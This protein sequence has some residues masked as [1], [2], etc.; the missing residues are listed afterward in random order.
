MFVSFVAFQFVI[1]CPNSTY[2]GPFNSC[3]NMW[4]FMDLDLGFHGH[5]GPCRLSSVLR[6][7]FGCIY[8]CVYIFIYDDVQLILVLQVVVVCCSVFGFVVV[9]FICFGFGC[10]IKMN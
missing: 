7:I 5:V 6:H 9:S 4:D 2:V 1:F 8:I 3:L 10:W